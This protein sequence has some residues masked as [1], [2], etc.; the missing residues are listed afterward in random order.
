MTDEQFAFR[1]SALLFQPRQLDHFDF[2][3]RRRVNDQGR[4]HRI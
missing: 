3:S 4:L 1:H 2:I